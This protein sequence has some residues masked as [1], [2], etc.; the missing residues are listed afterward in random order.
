MEKK[1]DE[2]NEPAQSWEAKNRT[3]IQETI[4][5]ID[6]EANDF[7]NKSHPKET[8]HDDEVDYHL[9]CMKSYSK[10]HN[11]QSDPPNFLPKIVYY[12]FHHPNTLHSISIPMPSKKIAQLN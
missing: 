5:E 10:Y 11:H 4:V 2:E 9:P 8:L 7:Y 3:E 1:L 6:E 12:L